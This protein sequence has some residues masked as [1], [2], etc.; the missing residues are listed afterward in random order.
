[1]KTW[2]SFPMLENII[3]DFSNDCSR[4]CFFHVARKI[5]SNDFTNVTAKIN[6]RFSKAL[7]IIL[8]VMRSEFQL[9][10]RHLLS[11]TRSF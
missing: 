2:K 6:L 3:N 7:I 10:L 5:K 4:N 1:M 11:V 9:R 8:E